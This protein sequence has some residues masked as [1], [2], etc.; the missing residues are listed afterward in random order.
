MFFFP[1]DQDL[2]DLKAIGEAPSWMQQEGF[3]TLRG[4]ASSKGYLLD[5]ETPRAMYQRL[6]TAAATILDRAD[7]EIDFFNLFWKGWLGGSS[8]VLA[9][10]GTDRGL[11][12]S[13]FGSMVCDSM[14]GII[15]HV[16][17]QSRLTWRG[18]GVAS[19]LSGIRAIGAE[20]KSGGT[21]DGILAPLRMLNA[22]VP[23]I[24]QGAMRRGSLAAYLNVDHPDI[25]TFLRMRQPEVD[26]D[27]RFMKTHHGVGITKEFAAKL[28]AGDE[29]AIALWGQ[30][31]TMRMETGEPY[32]IFNE[33]ANR[34]NP[35]AYD[36]L[37]LQVNGS[38][39]CCLEATEVVVT[40]EGNFAVKD[41]LNK[42]VEVWDGSNWVKTTFNYIGSTSTLI[43][44]HFA[45]GTSTRVTAGHRFPV[46]AE[47]QKRSEHLGSF[48]YAWALEAHTDA[49]ALETH[50]KGNDA[51]RGEVV[52]V[53]TVMLG[54]PQPMYCCDVPSTGM[55]AL[56]DGRMTGNSEIFL[57]TSPEYSFV[58]C[59]SSLNLEHYDDWKDTNAIELSIYFLEAVM[60]EFLIKARKLVGL[61]NAVRFAERSRALGL[62]VL[63]YHSYLQSHSIPFESDK[64]AAF[65]LAF[66][67][68]LNIKSDAA[69][70][71]LGKTYGV[72]EWCTELGRRH[73]HT[74]AIA[75]TLTN[76]A[77]CATSRSIEPIEVNA[78]FNDGAKGAFVYAN[79]Q[80]IPVL[81]AHGQHND[82]VWRSIAS[83]AGSVQHLDFL[84][85]HEKEVFKTAREIDQVILVKRAAD[86]GIF[87]DQGQSLNLFYYPDAD[88]QQVHKA[89]WL[90][91][92]SGLKS[93]YYCK[94]GNKLKAASVSAP[95][96]ANSE[97][98]QECTVCQ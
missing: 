62:G 33:A 86:R 51:V 89:H 8:P 13:C 29:D 87:I 55:F 93:L 43:E 19:H 47:S 59:L 39:L 1:V 3:R 74:T 27:Q 48:I 5:D 11:P 79:A 15:D 82:L 85:A 76:S 70:V 71:A 49:V 60:S 36:R 31:L 40:R 75:P 69:S 94:T 12:I 50:W 26:E 44:V 17:E 81:E 45:D 72:P 58:C 41:L 73:T 98:A 7:L 57:A 23:T 52:D 14:S 90:A 32:L 88:P 20:I 96:L 34:D 61:E 80:L 21:S 18:G 64:A 2:E 83:Q 42:L 63:G 4:T 68:K 78:G 37:G 67:K 56:A 92:T 10:F 91:Y 65:N 22:T 54:L 24:S 46:V 38:N 28:K 16:A 9:N 95:Q 35:P 66:F 97:N 6:A 53:N 84:T 25:Q 77:I 30:I